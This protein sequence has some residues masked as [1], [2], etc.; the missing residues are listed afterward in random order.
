[1]RGDCL[2]ILRAAVDRNFEV[3]LQTNG[4]LIDGKLAEELSQLPTIRVDI[5]L[6]GASE[7]VHDSITGVKGS[8]QRSLEALRALRERGVPLMIKTL[9]TSENIS[10]K[11]AILDLS[12][13]LE[14][15][16]LFS[17]ILFPRNDGSRDPLRFRLNDEQLEDF[18][19]FELEHL[20]S[21]YRDREGLDSSGVEELAKSFLVGPLDEEGTLSRS[22]GAGITAFA[23]NPYGDI[24]PCV[25]F[26]YVVG[27]ISEESFLQVWKHSR[28]LENMRSRNLELSTE[29]V[30]CRYLD[31]CA[32]C[33]ALSYLEDGNAFVRNQERCRQTVAW[34][35]RLS[36]ERERKK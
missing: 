27:N 34:M 16:V 21:F 6:Y 28:E 2:D 24:Y 10:E 5:S 29:C 7:K 20:A 13:Q 4:T 35:E 9:V 22:C 3:T 26:P 15:P 36:N 18:V 19:E 11:E 32:I 17:P 23:I 31:S 8:F 33:K 25:A 1:M 14:I 12:R 30:G